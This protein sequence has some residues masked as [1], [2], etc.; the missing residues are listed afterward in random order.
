[1]EETFVKYGIVGLM[2]LQTLVGYSLAKTSIE[3]MNANTEAVAG[4]RGAIERVLDRL[5]NA[6]A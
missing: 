6:D 3:V 1:M 5:E 2:A 4:L